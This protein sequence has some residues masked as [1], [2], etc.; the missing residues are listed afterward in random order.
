[1]YASGIKGL[2]IKNAQGISLGTLFEN[3]HKH[4][5]NNKSQR[6]KLYPTKPGSAKFR[7]LAPG[8]N[9]AQAVTGANND[10]WWT[11]SSGQRYKKWVLAQS[12]S[13]VCCETALQNMVF[14]APNGMGVTNV[15]H[16]ST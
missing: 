5:S 16:N 4:P 2:I 14:A 13:D 1:M 15:F 7:P 8:L 10:S 11:G 3:N 12:T 9:R 6:K